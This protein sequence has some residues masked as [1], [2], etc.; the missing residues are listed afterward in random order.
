MYVLIQK[1]KLFIQFY[2][3]IPK[4]GLHLNKTAV[5]LTYDHS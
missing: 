3:N 5:K 1:V 4:I 2:L